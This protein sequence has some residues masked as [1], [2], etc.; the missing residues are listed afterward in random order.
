MRRNYPLD[1]NALLTTPISRSPTSVG[2]TLRV[3]RVS[4]RTPSRASSWVT[5]RCLV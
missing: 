5:A 1:Y 2:A 3:V 4:S